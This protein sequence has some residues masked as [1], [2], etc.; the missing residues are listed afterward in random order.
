MTTD[1]GDTNACISVVGEDLVAWQRMAVRRKGN[2]STNIRLIFE[3][4][5]TPPKEDCEA[6]SPVYEKSSAQTFKARI[7]K[8]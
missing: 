7:F 2:T 3:E 8:P 6:S 5:K 1:V 4:V